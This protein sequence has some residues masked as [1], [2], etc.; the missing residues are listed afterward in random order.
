M[1]QELNVVSTSSAPS[2]RAEPAKH[3]VVQDLSAAQH[4][5]L[6]PGEPSRVCCVGP[7]LVNRLDGTLGDPL[8]L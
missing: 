3:A 5:R 6:F 7:V 8:S 4:R 1:S 2:L